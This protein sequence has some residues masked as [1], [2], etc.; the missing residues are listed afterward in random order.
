MQWQGTSFLFSTGRAQCVGLPPWSS[1]EC[2]QRG[3]TGR[4]KL[5]VITECFSETEIPLQASCFTKVSKGAPHFWKTSHA[6]WTA[7]S[8]K[9]NECFVCRFRFCYEIIE[10]QLQD[11]S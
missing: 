2:H 5:M 6:R 3:A 8:G 10:W 7:E 9:S 4:F 1:V 11:G